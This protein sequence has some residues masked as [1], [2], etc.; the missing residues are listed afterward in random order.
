MI[1]EEDHAKRPTASPKRISLEA[2]SGSMPCGWHA[3]DRLT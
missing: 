1:N 2:D 3:Q